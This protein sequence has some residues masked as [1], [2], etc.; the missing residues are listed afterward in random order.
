ML[1]L[2]YKLNA[3]TKIKNFLI[4]KKYVLEAQRVWKLNICKIVTLKDRLLLFFLS[5][6]QRIL[7]VT[8]LKTV[9]SKF[10]HFAGIN[11]LSRHWWVN[12]KFCPIYPY[13]AEFFK[14]AQYLEKNKVMMI[15]TIIITM[16]YI[17]WP[18]RRTVLDVC[19]DWKGAETPQSEIYIVGGVPSLPPYSHSPRGYL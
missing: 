3:K 10:G 8:E 7:K 2:K 4:I 9:L 18:E 11:V 13:A 15:R 5:G 17:F 19:V 14:N 16:K 6:K 1:T 12:N